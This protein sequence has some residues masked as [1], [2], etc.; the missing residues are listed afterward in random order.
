MYE[1]KKLIIIKIIKALV[2]LLKLIL[3]LWKKYYKNKS[4]YRF[5]SR[6]FKILF[7]KLKALDYINLKL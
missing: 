2:Y 5:R 1:R 3:P 7:D 4:K 6:S